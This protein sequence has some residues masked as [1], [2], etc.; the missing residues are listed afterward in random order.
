M[1]CS[2]QRIRNERQNSSSINGTSS[3]APMKRMASCAAP[4][5]AG[6]NGA[7]G[8][9]IVIHGASRLI[10]RKKMSTPAAI[11]SSDSRALGSVCRASSPY[12]RQQ[13]PLA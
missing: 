10:Q 9:P 11:A 6:L 2:S 13:P 12:S 8:L 1:G 3:A 5:S 7:L 4:A